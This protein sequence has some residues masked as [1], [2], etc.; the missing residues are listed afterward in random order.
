MTESFWGEF[1]LT[2]YVRLGDDLVGL[3]AKIAD[4]RH[5]RIIKQGGVGHTKKKTRHTL[6]HAGPYNRKGKLVLCTSQKTNRNL[7][8]HF[9]P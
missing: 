2:D 7:L 8:G 3:G 1:L 5:C 9:I 6:R 4:Y